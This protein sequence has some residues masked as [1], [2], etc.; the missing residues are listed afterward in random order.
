MRKYWIDL[1]WH[2]IYLRMLISSI[3]EVLLSVRLINFEVER[4]D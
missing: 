2:Q 4:N 3:A 1:N